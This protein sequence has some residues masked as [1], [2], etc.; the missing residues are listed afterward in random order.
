MDLS[1]AASPPTR[2]GTPGAAGPAAAA[3]RSACHRERE[4]CRITGNGERG[5][6]ARLP[7][8][9]PASPAGGGGRERQLPEPCWPGR[10]IG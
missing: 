5:A 1:R 6:T 8:A 3:V 2:R 7:I 10:S 4:S 9:A